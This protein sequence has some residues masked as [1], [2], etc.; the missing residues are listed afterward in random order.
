MIELLAISGPGHVA[1]LIL[2]PLAG[3]YATVN[4][5]T[6]GGPNHG[7]H[8]LIVSVIHMAA[9]SMKS[10]HWPRPLYWTYFGVLL[11]SGLLSLLVT[12]F[13]GDWKDRPV[14][15]ARLGM[16]ALYAGMLGILIFGDR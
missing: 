4:V 14:L 7:E 11:A 9:F 6:S 15:L 13:R 10:G 8:P 12:G 2:V 16:A 5:G 1:A 3:L